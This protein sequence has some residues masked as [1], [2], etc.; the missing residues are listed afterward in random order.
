MK[1]SF[2]DISNLYSEFKSVS[3]VICITDETDSLRTNLDKLILSCNAEDL[4]QILLCTHERTAVQTIKI[5]EEYKQRYPFVEIYSQQIKSS[6]YILLKETLPLVKGT[7][8]IYAAADNATDLSVVGEFVSKQKEN[9]NCVPCVSRWINGG[10]LVGYGFI[11]KLLSHLFQRFISVLYNN[12]YTE[13]SFPYQIASVRLYDALILNENGVFSF[14]EAKMKMLKLNVAFSEL[15]MT[16]RDRTD[17]RKHFRP[18]RVLAYFRIAF[19]VRF[20]KMKECINI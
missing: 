7:H 19:K 1:K 8:V 16:W 10:K 12:K 13:F 14:F 18:L 15:P 9:S 11:R 2:Y 6:G 20:M 5:A 17:G 4:V 3:V